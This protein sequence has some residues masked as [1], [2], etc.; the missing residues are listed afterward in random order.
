MLDVVRTKDIKKKMAI[1]FKKKRTELDKSY[2]I[3]FDRCL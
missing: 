1:H 2:L 3:F